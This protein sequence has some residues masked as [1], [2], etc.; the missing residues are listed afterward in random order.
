MVG[1]GTHVALVT[2]LDRLAAD[3]WGNVWPTIADFRFAT[4]HLVA[5][6]SPDR[7]QATAI[8]PWTSTGF[9][10]DGSPFDRP[11]RA[12]VVLTRETVSSPWLGRHTHFSLA[13][14]T[15]GRSHGKRG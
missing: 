14:G 1:F 11:G 5:L 8:V 9:H 2:G 3:Q 4:E 10:A 6:V 12:T 15:P 7:L 13:P